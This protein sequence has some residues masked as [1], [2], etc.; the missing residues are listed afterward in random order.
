[1]TPSKMAVRNLGT[2]F[3]C[4][5]TEDAAKSNA[6]P[7]HVIII[8]AW[9]QAVNTLVFYKKGRHLSLEQRTVLALSSVYRRNSHGYASVF[10]KSWWPKGKH[11]WLDSYDWRKASKAF[12]VSL[13]PTL[14]RSTIFFLGLLSPLFLWVFDRMA[15]FLLVQLKAYFYQTFVLQVPVKFYLNRE[16]G[17]QDKQ[18][19]FQNHGKLELS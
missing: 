17:A 16:T 5:A 3:C 11:L 14:S 13:V 18:T 7:N 1:M 10:E 12:D 4:Q 6:Q 9:Q 2:S 19:K 8:I 15:R